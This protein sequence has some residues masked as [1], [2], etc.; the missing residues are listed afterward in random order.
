MAHTIDDHPP[1]VEDHPS[2]GD[3]HHQEGDHL[4]PEVLPEECRLGVPRGDLL[5]I[6]HRLQQ[7]ECPQGVAG[8][9]LPGIAPQLVHHAEGRFI[10][11]IFSHLASSESCDGS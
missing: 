3:P 11:C 8:V 9:R 2:E 1:H 10:V 7:G 6:I 4:L 5:V